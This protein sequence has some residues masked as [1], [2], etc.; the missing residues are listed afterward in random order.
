MQCGNNSAIEA[1]GKACS[2]DTHGRQMVLE[3]LTDDL[4]LGGWK[5]GEKTG[6]MVKEGE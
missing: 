6:V 5:M 1:P 2:P 3:K 4:G